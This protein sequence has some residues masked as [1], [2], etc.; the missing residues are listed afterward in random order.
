MF[1]NTKFFQVVGKVVKNTKMN[2]KKAR[3]RKCHAHT[4][5]LITMFWETSKKCQYIHTYILKAGAKNGMQH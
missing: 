1:L 3:A 2:R 4:K 5:W